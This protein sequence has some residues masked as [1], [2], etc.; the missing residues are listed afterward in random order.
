[1]ALNFKK[2]SFSAAELRAIK[3]GTN[4]ESNVTPFDKTSWYTVPEGLEKFETPKQEV[5]VC[6]D[7]LDFTMGIKYH[8]VF[9]KANIWDVLGK[10]FWYM[11]I[12]VHEVFPKVTV[13]NKTFSPKK[14]DND[15]VCNFLWENQQYDFR[16]VK[17]GYTLMLLR[18]H[19]N[20]E[21]GIKDYKYVVHLDTNGKLANA[22]IDEWQKA[23]TMNDLEVI[24]FSKWDTGLT[25]KAFFHQIQAKVGNPFWGCDVVKFIERKNPIPESDYEFLSNLDLCAGISKPTEEDYAELCELIKEK[26]P[27]KDGTMPVPKEEPQ[28]EP[29]PEPQPVTSAEPD[30]AFANPVKLEEEEPEKPT[31]EEADEDW[32]N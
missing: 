27:S 9:M 28:P 3:Q 20:E 7:V 5:S 15:L 4:S 29:T 10:P 11:P 2:N 12:Q 25:V 21:L 16:R 30:A 32:I 26:V 14:V 8:P 13:C 31:Q 1:M 17:K 6:F 19:P 22:I 18:L 23:C 24:D